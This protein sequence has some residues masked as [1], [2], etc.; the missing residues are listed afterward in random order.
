VTEILNDPISG[1]T[2]T[3]GA[4]DKAKIRKAILKIRDS[5]SVEWRAEASK[6]IAERALALKD[7]LPEGP[8][9]AYWPYKSEADPLSALETLAGSTRKMCLP[10][11]AHPHMR[12]LTYLPGGPM[13]EAGFGT[14]GPPHD[15]EE[16]R[17]SV[18]LVPLSGFDAQCNRIGWGKGHYDRAIERLCSDGKPLMTIGIAFSFQEAAFVPAEAHDRPLDC[19]VTEI[20]LFERR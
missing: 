14:M 10:V 19:V 8:I 4:L 12:F 11:I 7:R 2:G 6:A 16:L 20:A 1:E 17:P 13:V 3:G 15:A 9:A 5:Q 18:L